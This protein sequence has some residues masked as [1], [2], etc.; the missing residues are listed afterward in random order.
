[1]KHFQYQRSIVGYHGCEKAVRDQ[2]VA[3]EGKLHPSENDYDWL[4]KG[5]YFWEYGPERALEWAKELKR[6]GKIKQPSVIG[7]IIHLGHSFDL[8]DIRYTR[9]LKEAY[10]SFVSS[11]E[12]N[13]KELPQNQ[14][15]SI[16]DDDLL[17][18]RGDCALINWIIPL[19]ESKEG[20]SYDTVRGLFREGS[21]VF[22]GSGIYEKNHI[23]I[24]VRDTSCIAGY[25]LPS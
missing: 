18:R 11:L 5:I 15:L 23:Q 20:R 21:P 6:R 7:A 19:L 13:G 25:F 14:P 17:L 22:P 16:N 9:T 8:L 1:M 12:A 2:V 3:G 10:P 24:A 4:G